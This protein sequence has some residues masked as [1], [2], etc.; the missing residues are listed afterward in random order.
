MV[1]GLPLAAAWKVSYCV[2]QSGHSGVGCCWG[3]EEVPAAASLVDWMLDDAVVLLDI[4][5]ILV[6]SAAEVATRRALTRHR[7]AALMAHQPGATRPDI[8]AARTPLY[9]SDIKFQFQLK[10]L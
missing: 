10:I 9:S 8:G 7:A 5:G 2:N 6:S 4:G 1:P 3:T